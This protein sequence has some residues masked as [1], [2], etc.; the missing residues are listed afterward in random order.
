M[1]PWN[2]SWPRSPMGISAAPSTP[3]AFLVTNLNTE[4]IMEPFTAANHG[5]S[6]MPF[7]ERST[8]CLHFI[9]FVP[10]FELW[11]HVASQPATVKLGVT[12]IIG[13]CA[14]HGRSRC[15]RLSNSL[16]LPMQ[17]TL[18]AMVHTA[19][20]TVNCTNIEVEWF[21]SMPKAWHQPN[22]THDSYHSKKTLCIKQ[23]RNHCRNH[24]RELHKRHALGVEARFSFKP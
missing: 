16:L 4:K 22:K 11:Y 2:G 3:R 7:T 8:L 19:T 1:F 23:K 9:C 20:G 15:V 17:A 10:F 21:L 14:K 12:Q 13:F 24:P 18:L 5:S 6:C